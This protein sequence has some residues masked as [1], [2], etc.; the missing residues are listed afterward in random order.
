MGESC[1]EMR[2]RM[3][4]LAATFA[5]VLLCN[6]GILATAKEED[7]SPHLIQTVSDRDIYEGMAELVMLD[8][9]LTEREDIREACENIKSCVVRIEMDG[10]YGSGLVWK[11]GGSEILI[12]SNRHV[13]DF[14]QDATGSVCFAQGAAAQAELLGC[15]AMYDIGFLRIDT[16]QLDG[17]QLCRLR[18]VNTAWYPGT[19]ESALEQEDC[20]PYA[21]YPGQ[22]VLH[23]GSGREQGSRLVYDAVIEDL[24]FYI[25]DFEQD[26]IYCKGYAREG[27]S[28]GGTF[29]GFG[30][31]IGML[32]G[33]TDEGET[34]SIPVWAIEEA[35]E[36]IIEKLCQP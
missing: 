31:F 10:A 22:K 11:L 2:T 1:A 23:I 29:D 18:Q 25:P 3:K 4:V 9:P 19:D 35:Y 7:E 16:G 34:V 26:M 32:S 28:G 36:E 8:T 20:A 33:G 24:A 5:C 6:R 14:W 17:E 21:P 27:M 30:H 12:V 13:L 15:S